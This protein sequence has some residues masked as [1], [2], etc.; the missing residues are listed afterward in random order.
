MAVTE[1][2]G[3]IASGDRVEMAARFMT[4]GEIEKS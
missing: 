2:P 3:H 4:A 1:W